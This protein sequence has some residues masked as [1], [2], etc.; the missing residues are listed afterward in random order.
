MSVLVLATVSKVPF[1]V[2]GGVLAAWAVIVSAIG[3][4]R[5]EFPEG[6]TQT[7]AVIALSVVLVIAAM[8]T[9]VLTAEIPRH[10]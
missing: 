1:Y 7:R 2:A 4:S 8:A 10:V 9:A 3:I 5:P 6:P